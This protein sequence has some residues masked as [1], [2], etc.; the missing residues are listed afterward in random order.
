MPSEA[1]KEGSGE[2]EEDIKQKTFQR[3]FI[4]QKIIYLINK[5]QKAEYR[6][7]PDGNYK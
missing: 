7:K 4:W 1:D 3:W 6:G 5:V 2:I